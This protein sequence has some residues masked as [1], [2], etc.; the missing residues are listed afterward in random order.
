MTIRG[1]NAVAIRGALLRMANA[2]G[3]STVNSEGVLVFDRELADRVET[4]VAEMARREQ[5]MRQVIEWHKP[6]LKRLLDL[7]L[8]VDL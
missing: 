3:V 4:V 2:L 6:G 7:N 1:T 8:V 5:R